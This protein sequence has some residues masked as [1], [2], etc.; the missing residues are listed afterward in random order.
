M[1]LLGAHDIFKPEETTQMFSVD[2]S[3]IITHENYQSSTLSN[4]VSLLKILSGIVFNNYVQPVK[5]GSEPCAYTDFTVRKKVI[6]K[7][8]DLMISR[9]LQ[10]DGGSKAIAKRRCPIY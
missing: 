1:V 9:S 4:D 3:E 2:K 8:F 5:L 10:V 6:K 7:K